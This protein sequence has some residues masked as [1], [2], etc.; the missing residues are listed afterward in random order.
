MSGTC[1]FD[2]VAEPATNGARERYEAL[3]RSIR[4]V[5]SQRWM[6]TEQT[7]RRENPKR[8]FSRAWY[9]PQ[10]HYHNDLEI[11]AALDL[12]FSDHFSHNEPDVFAPLR[13]A[14]LTHGDHYM[15]LVD[16]ASYVEADPGLRTLYADPDAWTQKAIINVA[17]SGKFSSDRT[18]AE[19]CEGYLARQAVPRLLVENACGQHRG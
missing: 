8:V 11:R 17:S 9:S 3:A 2:N 15:H 4:D 19:L 5:L 12:M 7:Y 1:F 6:L 18:I 14:L 16:L 10:W 13:D